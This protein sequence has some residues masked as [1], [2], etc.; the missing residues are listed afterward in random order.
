MYTVYKHTAPNGKVYIGITK[1]K[2]EK[3]WNNGN[4]YKQNKHLYSAIQKYTW[5]NFK[6]E[7]VENGL[8]KEQACD[9]EIELI[10]EYHATDRRYG[11]NISIGGDV[12]R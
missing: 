3:R 5:E 6:H 8:T 11:Y 1:Q 10:A 9:L 12:E 2:P 7:I 4:G